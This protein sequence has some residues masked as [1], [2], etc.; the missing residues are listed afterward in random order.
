MS[1]MTLQQADGF[2][3]IPAFDQVLPMARF[4]IDGLRHGE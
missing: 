3:E 1:E 4:A 2:F